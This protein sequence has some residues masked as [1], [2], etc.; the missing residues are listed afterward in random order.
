MNGG[1]DLYPMYS[2]IEFTMLSSVVPALSAA[3]ERYNYT[4]PEEM[5]KILEII[6]KSPENDPE[7]TK[8]LI[9]V[10][11]SHTNKLFTMKDEDIKK[12]ILSGAG[13]EMKAAV[14]CKFGKYSKVLKFNE[15][16]LKDKNCRGNTE[17]ICDLLPTIYPETKEQICNTDVEEE[18]SKIS[19]YCSYYC[20]TCATEV[21]E[22]ERK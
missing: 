3:S 4:Y 18:E 20:G 19:D 1:V 7:N 2:S 6:K 11:N 15:L 13:K 5:F 17:Y 21:E 22:K 8:R 16:Y 12:N 10:K 14:D 9:D